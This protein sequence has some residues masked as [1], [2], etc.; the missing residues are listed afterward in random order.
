MKRSILL[1]GI[2]LTLS[3][4]SACTDNKNEVDSLTTEYEIQLEEKDKEI[5]KLREEIRQVNNELE[6]EKKKL[7][8]S[9]DEFVIFDHKARNIIGHIANKEFEKLL[10]EYDVD[11]E[12]INEKIYFK[13]LGNTETFFPIEIASFPMYFNFYNSQSEF[14]EVGYFMYGYDQYGSERKYDIHFKFGKNDEF[15]YVGTN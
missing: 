7:R 4:L 3:L 13:K 14:T 8:D 2:V 9:F 6:Q 12:V 5:S 1:I 10:S 11:F 15:Q